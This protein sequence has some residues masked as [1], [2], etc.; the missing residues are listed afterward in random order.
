ML[1]KIQAYEAQLAEDPA[2]L[3]PARCPA[4]QLT[5]SLRKHELRPREFWCCLSNRV[6]RVASFVLRVACKACGCRTTVL[7]DFAIRHK[8]YVASDMV[9]AAERYLLDETAT[10]ETAAKADGRHAF[11]DSNGAIRARSTVHRWIGFLGSLTSLLAHATECAMQADP[12]FSPLAEMRHIPHHRYRTDARRE[13]LGRAHLLLRVRSTLLRT[14]N[15]E[16]FPTVAT[17]AAWQ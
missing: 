3:F 17:E 6:T 10:H 15:H 12:T 13:I 16:L 5:Q 7:P 11:H 14:L 4:C 1:A 9:D 8:R 2:S